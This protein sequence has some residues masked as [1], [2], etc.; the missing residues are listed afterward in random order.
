MITKLRL[1][2]SITILF[3]SFYGFTQDN[4]WKSGT[5]QPTTVAN[6]VQD[7]D[8]NKAKS[9]VLDEVLFLNK[10]EESTQ[11]KGSRIVY[12]P[13]VDGQ[14]EAFTVQEH[15]VFAPKLA[16]KYPGIKSYIGYGVSNREDRIRFSMS[17]KGLQ[18]MVVHGDQKKST[19]MQLAETN[20]GV[21]VVYSRDAKDVKNDFLCETQSI[22][23][24][25]VGSKASKLV[26]DQMLRTYRLAIS[27]SGEY[28][29]YHGGSKAD[30]LAAINATLTRVNEVFEV[31]LGIRL[32]LIATTDQVIY[33]DAASDPYTGS[34]N[35]EAQNTFTTVIGSENYDV[36]H[37]FHQG[38]NGGN[39]GSVGTVC[40]D[41]W[42]GRAYSSSSVPE[43]ELFDMDYVAH[44]IGHQFGANHTWSFESEG[45]FV[46]AEPGSGSTIMG[47]A[48]ITDGNNVAM[49]GDD[50]F[51]YYSIFQIAEYIQSASCGV[52]TPITNNPPLVS[53]L[54]NY[55]IPKAT[56]FVL[57]GEATDI[58]ALDVLT[59]TWEQLDDG[60][61]TRANFGPENPS[62]A[63]FRSLK[64]TT[65]PERYFPE[66]ERVLQGNLTQINPPEGSS[67][68]TVSNVERDLNF[69]FTVRDNVVGGGQV[70]S[71]TMHVRVVNAA[72]PFV[73]TSQATNVSYQSGSSQQVTWDVANTHIAPVN[74]QT[75]SIYLST[76]A[77]LTFTRLLAE[78]VPNDGAQMVQIPSVATATARIK[79]KA[80]NNVF[81]A[82]NSTNFTVTN[83]NV[84]LQFAALEHTVCQPADLVVPFVYKTNNGFTETSTFSVN[85]APA[86][87][88][89]TFSSNTATVNNTNL[90]IEFSNT[91]AVADGNYALT[92]LS[93]S[94]NNT[95]PV[96][97]NLTINNTDYNDVVLLLPLNA[98]TEVDMGGPLFW[99]QNDNY[100]S[101]DVE[102]ATDNA[103][104]T[105]VETATTL[106]TSYNPIDLQPET[107]YYW[108]VKPKNECGEGVFGPAFSFTT[109]LVSCMDKGTEDLPQEI[110]NIGTP[111]VL[112]KITFLDD[113]PISDVNVT[114]NLTHSFLADLTISLI[115]PQGTRVVL[116][117][118][119]CGDYQDINAVFDDAADNF[120]CGAGGGAA[121]NGTVKPL[122]SLA[123]LNGESLL[124]DWILEVKDGASSDGGQ[125][126]DFA[127]NIC[128]AGSFRPDADNDGIFD[129]G[130]DLCLGTP[131]GASVNLNGCA[132]YRYA[133]D[134]FS[135]VVKSESCSIANNGEVLIEAVTPMNYA[136]R[137][138]E[139]QPTNF[140]DAISL[141]NLEAGVHT[142]CITGSNG[143][144]TYEPYCVDVVIT[145]PDDL[146]VFSTLS[147]DG[148]Q[149]EV[150][151][152]G[153]RLYSIELNGVLEQT[154]I[155]SHQLKL[156]NG[157]NTLKIYTSLECQGV[158]EERFFVSSK[159]VISPNP[160]ADFTTAYVGP[161]SG[162]VKVA[163]YT[164]GG[165]LIQQK[166][167]SVANG[168][169]TMELSGLAKGM[170]IVYFEGTEII[171]ATK[172][173]KK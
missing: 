53:P 35:T 170:Y 47:Y 158:Y 124:G 33:T 57:N 71:E 96:T 14:L 70:A 6:S 151:L 155:G 115:S 8:V 129:D 38:P 76:D 69:A 12:F 146:N 154:E 172:L 28:T 5:L 43:G 120:E 95:T 52:P 20:K 67:W 41:N 74:A 88:G 13:T 164:F 168:K 11:N 55:V 162:S 89:V 68:E 62:G 152:S 58:D 100:T 39:A 98:A 19:F 153:A 2:F 133:P 144:I 106:F 122:G 84:E 132:I 118:N 157:L 17:H 121:I 116:T 83:A 114:L 156:K 9:F 66:L 4:Y 166:N 102:I 163:I 3:G 87:L 171:G 91:A 77:G 1:V 10:L 73:V 78:D 21:Y 117:S 18:S 31:D 7:L 113:L 42:K 111:T 81:Y 148:R 110:S 161:V 29:N 131:Q 169:I 104:A 72:G 97:V 123:S 147:I 128:V 48:G 99:G 49:N 149:V 16:A 135:I 142:I 45:T 44:E 40:N 75:V 46:Q 141:S 26:D 15:A 61:V 165:S 150:E 127:L 82:V 25:T 54:A 60:V 85:G 37:L 65:S 50:Y 108:R 105:I 92:I 167:Y 94:Q 136:V 103:F 138:S 27:A 79:V 112:S 134:N 130:D 145:E 139:G 86:N 140:T 160:V 51:H 24:K 36:G 137:I 80:S 63:N 22:L 59:Y 119:S 125:V 107:L 93:A 56:A 173:I 90:T 32:E 23:E 109:A 143:S 101:Y 159:P 34:L 64:P 30:A 126:I